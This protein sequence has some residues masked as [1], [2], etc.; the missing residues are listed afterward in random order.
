M[1]YS[2]HSARVARGDKTL[3]NTRPACTPEALVN[4]TQDA[5][6]AFDREFWLL[7]LNTCQMRAK[8]LQDE[9]ASV[10]A[11]ANTIRKRLGMKEREG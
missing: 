1:A 10:L 4:A 5:Q 7:M 3:T 2:S 9:R 6:E 8:A 11:M